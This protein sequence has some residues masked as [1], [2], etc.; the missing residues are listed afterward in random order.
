ME[1][2]INAS[3]LPEVAGRLLIGQINLAPSLPLSKDRATSNKKETLVCESFAEQLQCLS[4]KHDTFW[5]ANRWLYQVKI[6]G[7]P[8]PG[9]P[10]LG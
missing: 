3:L 9:E 6:H 8:S 2:N 10:G 4:D 1:H 7:G 5:D